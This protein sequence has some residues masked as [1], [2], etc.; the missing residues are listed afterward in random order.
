[1]TV[2]YGKESKAL[3]PVQTSKKKGFIHNMT[4]TTET[5]KIVKT[6][7]TGWIL[8]FSVPQCVSGTTWV[9]SV[10]VITAL[11]PL[12]KVKKIM[13]LDEKLC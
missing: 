9:A 12:I 3:L 5:F 6:L 7:H 8:V 10:D 4:T 13:T 1:M 11:E 2:Y